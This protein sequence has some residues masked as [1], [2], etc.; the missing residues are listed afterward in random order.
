M[1]PILDCL[2]DDMRLRNLAISTQSSYVYHVSMFTR[3][4]GKSPD[5]IGP[6]EIRSYQ[7]YLSMEK[8]AAPATIAIA[9]SA[10]RF[11]YGVTLQ[12]NWI[13]EEAIPMPKRPSALPAVLSPDEVLEF[14]ECVLG[15]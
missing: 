1:K 8:R 7:L 5:I 11:L 12:R 10:L 3:Y 6:S 14:L 9:V 13:V 4:F 2:L 15:R